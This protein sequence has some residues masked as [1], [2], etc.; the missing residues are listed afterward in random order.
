MIAALIHSQGLL[1][2]DQAWT[3]LDKNAQEKIISMLPD[4]RRTEF[5]T[6][7]QDGTHILNQS[8]LMNNSSWNYFIGC[9]RDDIEL[10]RNKPAWLQDA[11]TAYMERQVGK[12][13][14]WKEKEYEEF[15]GT[16]QKLAAGVIAGSSA[17]L[18]WDD[19]V[20]RGSFKPGDVF[21]YNRRV[22]GILVKKDVEVRLMALP[23]GD[24][25]L[26]CYS[27]LIL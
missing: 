18:K 21:Q 10:G 2:D 24:A 4:A 7:I 16:R 23:A 6:T 3:L 13:D 15:W 9:F 19:L 22:S 25:R 1:K 14:S 17:S 20:E 27:S 12:Y 5:V 11:N 26:T 8:A